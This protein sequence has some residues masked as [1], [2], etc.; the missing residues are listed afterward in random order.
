[1]FDFVEKLGFCLMG[2]STLAQKS[3]ALIYVVDVINLPK[4]F[5]KVINKT[6]NLVAECV[7]EGSMVSCQKNILEHYMSFHVD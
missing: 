1:M 7:M 5:S 4:L 6:M 2:K 3:A